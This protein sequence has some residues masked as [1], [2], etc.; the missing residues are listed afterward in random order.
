MKSEIHPSYGPVVF[1]DRSAS[2]QVLTRSTIVAQLG[3]DAPTI[4][5]SDGSTYPVVDVQVSSA[6]HPFWTGRSRTIDTE[7]RI[8]KFTRRYGRPGGAR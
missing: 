8:E 7:G 4:T 5:W 2:S 1:R 3:D 6:S